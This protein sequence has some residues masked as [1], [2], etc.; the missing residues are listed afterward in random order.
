MLVK[1]G[2][3]STLA[4]PHIL[5]TL[6][7]FLQQASQIPSFQHTHQPSFCSVSPSLKLVEGQHLQLF[8][9]TWQG[10]SR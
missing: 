1:L 2:I 10:E 7:A 3:V 5:Q 8:F 4:L 9:S 6:T